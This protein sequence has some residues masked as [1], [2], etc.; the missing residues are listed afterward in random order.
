MC[1]NMRMQIL[2]RAFYGWLAYHRHLKIV[3]IHLVCLINENNKMSGEIEAEQSKDGNLELIKT[4]EMYLSEKKKLDQPLWSEMAKNN[5][6][7]RTKEAKLFHKIVYYNGIDLNMRKIVWP[8]IMEHFSLDMSEDEIAESDKVNKT[9]YNKL[10]EEWKPLEDYIVCMERKKSIKAKKL[11]QE[12]A[13]AKKKESS[14]AAEAS[15][16]PANVEAEANKIETKPVQ[17]ISEKTKLSGSSSS[18]TNKKPLSKRASFFAFNFLNKKEKAKKQ[19]KLNLIRQN[20]L[21]EKDKLDLLLR[22]DSSISNDVFL[23][24]SISATALPNNS[25]AFALISRLTTRNLF[26]KLMQRSYGQDEAN[27]VAEEP[28][29]VIDGNEEAE[30]EEEEVNGDDD[31]ET[32]QT[33]KEIVRRVLANA[34]E[35]MKLSKDEKDL[36]ANSVVE[37]SGGVFGDES[38]ANLEAKNHVA[39]SNRASSVENDEIGMQDV[40]NNSDLDLHVKSL[41]SVYD[42]LKKSQ[43]SQSLKIKE[44]FGQETIEAFALNMHRIDKDVTR[45]D[46]NYWYFTSNDNLQ[47]LK[48]IMYTYIWENLSIGYI[49]G[50]CDLIAPLLVIFDDGKSEYIFL[51]LID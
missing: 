46:R 40:D 37:E 1:D 31:D 50:M 44:Q 47:K 27:T 16:L 38:S 9:E 17:R 33:A 18:L 42:E 49:Q 43:S 29:T 28:T 2:S 3:R 11:L 10:I 39:S 21:A 41:P 36:R 34:Q 7:L 15:A 24:E 48:N 30:E 12:I 51:D 32:M 8:F 25:S 35:M 14:E 20:S 19:G 4:M 26:A 23:E 45:C 22:K 6:R 5:K 13:I